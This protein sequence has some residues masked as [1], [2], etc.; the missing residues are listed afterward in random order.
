MRVLVTGAG[1][2][3]GSNLAAA[4]AQQS[5]SVMGTWRTHPVEL[6]GM[7]TVALDMTDRGA[8]VALAS[9]FEPDVL[10]H[11]ACAGTLG[12]FER[13]SHL[14]RLELLGVEHT[15]AAARTARSSYVLVSCDWV[16]SGLRPPGER[17]DERDEPDPMNAYGRARLQA[18]EVVRDAGA[19]S[20]ITRVADVYG[21]NL[22]QP[23]RRP[24]A[25]DPLASHVWGRSGDA[26]RFVSRLRA[27]EPL[28]APADVYRTPTYAWDYAQRVCE[29]VAQG[30]EGVFH[31]AGPDAVHRREYLRL[32][33]RAGGCDPELV[34]P[35]S[36]A[37]MLAAGGEDPHL[38]LP[39]NTALDCEKARAAL[40]HPSVDVEAGLWLMSDQ[41]RRV[42]A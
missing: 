4:A 37:E 19:P 27:G 8:C 34:R 15:L 3:V 7:S 33:A 35:G 22:S 28:P 11:A 25:A 42:L 9:N 31:L 41:L 21:V 13:E 36:V 18:E 20:L 39:P 24:G 2:L 17:W 23:V 14:A 10:V 5:W 30:R 16:F 12:Q 29:L 6:V 38:P 40:G 26:L 1:G 32:V